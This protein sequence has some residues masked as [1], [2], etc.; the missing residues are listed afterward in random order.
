M[1]TNRAIA[2]RYAKA[3]FELKDEKCLMLVG[4]LA[5]IKDDKV[6]LF[7][8]DPTISA[9][10]KAE[11]IA[12]SFNMNKSC[13]NLLRIIFEHKRFQIFHDLY[14]IA[15]AMWLRASGKERVIVRSAQ[16]LDEDDLNA[17]TKVVKQVRRADPVFKVIY[18]PELLA[19]ITIDFEDSVVDLSAAGALKKAA[20]LM[21]GGRLNAY[22]PR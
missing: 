22:K 9:K 1:R 3:L 6:R 14:Q 18:D 2:F 20:S 15:Q 12:R 16:I 21:H 5:S 11:V 7:I 17:I 13:E 10:V 4:A 19:G 8:G